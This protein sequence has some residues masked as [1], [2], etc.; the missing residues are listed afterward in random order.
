[1]ATSATSGIPTKYV[2]LVSVENMFLSFNTLYLSHQ[3]LKEHNHGRR[4]KHIFDDHGNVGYIYYYFFHG[5]VE[6]NR[7]TAPVD[8]ENNRSASELVNTRAKE[9]F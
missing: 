8:K 3:S 2:S 9:F 6:Q 1:M 5:L 7:T 4:K